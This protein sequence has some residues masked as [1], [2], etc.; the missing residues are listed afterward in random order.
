[1]L[2]FIACGQYLVDQHYTSPARLAGE[3]GSAGGITVGGALTWRPDLF[4]VILDLVGMSDSL[5][6]ETEPNGPPNVVRIRDR[7]TRP[8]STASTR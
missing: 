4:G 7:P 1:M 3:G 8:A 2:D 5:R 6:F